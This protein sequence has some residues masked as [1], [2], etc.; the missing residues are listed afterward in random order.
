LKKIIDKGT[1][2]AAHKLEAAEGDIEFAEGKWTV[3]GTDK[4]ISFGDV[5]LTAYVPHD[6]PEGLEPGMDFSSFYAGAFIVLSSG[7]SAYLKIS[8]LPE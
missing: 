1:K 5:A 2:I 4:S 3:K 8:Q 6:Y 7:F